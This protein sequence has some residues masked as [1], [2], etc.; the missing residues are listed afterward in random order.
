MVFSKK[1]NTSSPIPKEISIVLE[2][3]PEPEPWNPSFPSEDELGYADDL[4]DSAG[5]DEDLARELASRAV[6][7]TSSIGRRD[8][9]LGHSSSGRRSS[10]TSSSRRASLGQ[11]RSP[12]RRQTPKPEEL[13][14]NQNSPKRQSHRARTVGPAVTADELGCGDSNHSHWMR[15]RSRFSVGAV[16][17]ALPTRDGELE[18]RDGTGNSSSSHNS[19]QR[20]RR[21]LSFN[22]QRRRSSSG[23]TSAHLVPEEET[24]RP[25]QIIPTIE[26]QRQ[27]RRSFRR[28]ISN[29]ALEENAVLSTTKKER[30]GDDQL[31]DSNTFELDIDWD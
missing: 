22:K 18:D 27:C 19:Q 15:R 1:K 21:N 6:V 23:A 9:G 31:G 28:S 5:V 13:G 24:H 2:V 17:T 25:G 4:D 16:S 10:T 8:S 11:R 3:T 30:V 20:S 14:C 29:A 7:R 12:T 26:H